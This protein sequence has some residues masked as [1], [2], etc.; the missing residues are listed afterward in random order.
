MWSGGRKIGVAFVAK[1]TKVLIGWVVV[2]ESKV[3]C[4][5][6]KCFGG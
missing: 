5:K 1:N 2:E 4:R 6:C 3:W